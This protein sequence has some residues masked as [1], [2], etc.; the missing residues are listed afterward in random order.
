ME[1][2]LISKD[3]FIKMYSDLYDE[4]WKKTILYRVGF[5]FNYE[6]KP[7]LEWIIQHKRILRRK[8]K[9]YLSKLPD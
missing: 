8:D 5:F 4:S 3:E 1:I 2:S 7:S 6:L 9:K